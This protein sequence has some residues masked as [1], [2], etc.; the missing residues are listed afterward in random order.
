[1][2]ASSNNNNFNNFKIDVGKNQNKY[3]KFK[4]TGETQN[5]Q[6]AFSTSGHSGESKNGSSMDQK[7]YFLQELSH[8]Y[9][10]QED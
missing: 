6:F 8:K 5:P 3:G 10:L 7:S 2:A 4:I 1:M 9:R